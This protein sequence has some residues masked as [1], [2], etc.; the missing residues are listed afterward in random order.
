MGRWLIILW[1]LIAFPFWLSAATGGPDGLHLH[2]VFHPVYILF[3]ATAIVALLRLRSATVHRAVRGL[4]LALVVAQAAAIAGQVGEEIAV[5]QHGGLS[6]GKDV[7]VDPLH[8]S[9]AWV[10]IPGLLASQ[11]LLI[12]LT[13]AAL[14]AMRGE[15]RLAASGGHV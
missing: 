1:A 14:L 5:L 12:A 2:A 11:L 9:S 8:M 3:C 15:H 7:F 6:A 13:V 4:S 10:T